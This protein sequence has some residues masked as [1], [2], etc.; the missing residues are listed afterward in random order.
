MTPEGFDPVYLPN[1]NRFMGDIILIHNYYLGGGIENE[2][3]WF[4][5]LALNLKPI[6]PCSGHDRQNL[7]FLQPVVSD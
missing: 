1:S 6:K 4:Q 7:S 2:K 3:I 5:I